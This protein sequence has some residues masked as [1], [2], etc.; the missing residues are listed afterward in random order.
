MYV[1]E[2]I[3]KKI[4]FIVLIT[5]RSST[6]RCIGMAAL[7]LFSALLTSG[8]I[9]DIFGD[10]SGVLQGNTFAIPMVGMI[11]GTIPVIILGTI[12]SFVLDRQK[13]QFNYSR[14][15]EEINP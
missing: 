9:L 12:Y 15:K 3:G 2:A 10:H 13:K 5:E 11:I 7:V 1:T 14:Q 4:G 6:F 8:L